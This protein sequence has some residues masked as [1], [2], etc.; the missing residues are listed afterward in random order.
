MGKRQRPGGRKKEMERAYVIELG[1][2][3]KA[4]P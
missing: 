3:A 1:I 2:I 4:T